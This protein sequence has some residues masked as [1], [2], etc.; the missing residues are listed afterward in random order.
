VWLISTEEKV[1]PENILGAGDAYVAAMV[2]KR[3]TE[4]NASMLEVARVRLRC[5]T[6]E[7]QK[8]R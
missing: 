6:C 2:Y 4:R 8:T 7:D 3:L 1:D 5:R